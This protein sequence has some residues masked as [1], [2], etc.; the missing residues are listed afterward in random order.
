MGGN[1]RNFDARGLRQMNKNDCEVGNK[2]RRRR[3]E[4]RDQE[5]ASNFVGI[6]RMMNQRRFNLNISRLVRLDSGFSPPP[7]LRCLSNV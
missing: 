4:Q 5:I 6:R 7:P 3:G 2:G 1:Q